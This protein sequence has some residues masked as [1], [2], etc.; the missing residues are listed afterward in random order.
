[1]KSFATIILPAVIALITSCTLTPG[2]PGKD[3]FDGKDGKDGKDGDSLLGSVFEIEG[4]F[5]ADNSYSLYFAFPSDFIVYDSDIVLVYL[6]WDVAEANDGSSLDVWRLLPQ[7]IVIGDEG[8]LQYNYDYTVGDVQVFLEGTI[9]FDT[10][11]PAEAENQVFRIAVL[12]AAYAKNKNLD[13]HDFNM[14]MKQ[15]NSNILQGLPLRQ[16]EFIEK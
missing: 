3:G 15:C 9:D 13:I 12:P 5:T 10:L 14:V 11:L 8:I 6:L 16:T 4:D 2:P 1:M 7:T